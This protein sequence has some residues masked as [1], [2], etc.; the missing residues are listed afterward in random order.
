MAQMTFTTAQKDK[1]GRF[2]CGEYGGSDG[3]GLLACVGIQEF[4]PARTGGRVCA[5]HGSSAGKRS[6]KALY[7]I[8]HV[9]TAVHCIN[10]ALQVGTQKG[11][12]GEIDSCGIGRRGLFPK[13]PLASG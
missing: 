12:A 5:C 4:S 13:S 1:A 11:L 2:A 9:K 8:E 3:D 7:E 6:A 10:V